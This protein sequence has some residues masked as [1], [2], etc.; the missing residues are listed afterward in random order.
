MSLYWT[1]IIEPIWNLYGTYMEPIWNLY[2]TYMEPIWNL[3]GTY[4]E[5]IWNLYGTY[6]EPIWVY[7]SV[8]QKGTCIKSN[9][10]GT[11]WRNFTV[12]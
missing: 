12:A 10:I 5:P 11:I 1:F 7:M 6:M 4:M 3:Y 2:G 8:R 9:D